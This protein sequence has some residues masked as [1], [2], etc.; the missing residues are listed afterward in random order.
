[1]PW[2]TQHRPHGME[3]KP[4]GPHC[5]QRHTQARLVPG[6]CRWRGMLFPASLRYR[7]DP[8][9]YLAVGGE[10]HPSGTSRATC[11]VA[12]PF[13][14]CYLAACAPSV[15]SDCGHSLQDVPLSVTRTWH[16]CRGATG[17]SPLRCTVLITLLR[18]GGALLH[19]HCNQRIL[20]P[21]TMPPSVQHE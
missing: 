3:A 14:S 11:M 12:E 2:E 4:S 5:L 8:P 13:S 15:G 1:M 17:R 9:P 7:Q 21:N 6:T 20:W 16:P 18:G 19:T 10:V